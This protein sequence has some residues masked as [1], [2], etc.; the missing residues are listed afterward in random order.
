MKT[1]STTKVPRRHLSTNAY[2]SG[3]SNVIVSSDATALAPIAIGERNCEAAL[4]RP[5]RWVRDLAR[6]S[7]VP[8]LPGKM[9]CYSAAGLMALF[10]SE[11]G[12]DSSVAD[13]GE[14]VT[15]DQI[16]ARLGRKRAAGSR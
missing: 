8:K 1:E 11:V 10:A 14:P 4:G 15:S 3:Q 16:L 2:Q 9:P 6:A 5:W 13:E 12:D 7:G